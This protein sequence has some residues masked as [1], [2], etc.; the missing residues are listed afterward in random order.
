MITDEIEWY[1]ARKH[2][3]DLALE[4]FFCMKDII[5]NENI[6]VAEFR[7]AVFQISQ[8]NPAFTKKIEEM[9][10]Q[11]LRTMVRSMHKKY[12]NEES[13]ETYNNYINLA[14]QHFRNLLTF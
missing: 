5:T 4:V 6:T 1:V 11:E 12:K 14:R 9:N 8:I 7:D 10:W 13:H 2:D 3:S